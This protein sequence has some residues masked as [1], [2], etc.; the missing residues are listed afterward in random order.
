MSGR[1][2][3]DLSEPVEITNPFGAHEGMHEDES[4]S[5]DRFICAACKGEFISDPSM[6]DAMREVEYEIDTQKA[7][8]GHER[9][10]S[11]C[12]DCYPKVMEWARERGLIP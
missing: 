1:D 9:V 7:F 3:W 12:D 10:G 2:D 8:P 11:V 6:T 4:G 5:G